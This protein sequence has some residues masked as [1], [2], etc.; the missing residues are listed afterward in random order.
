MCRGLHYC[1][2][3]LHSHRPRFCGPLSSCRACL[4]AF[5]LGHWPFVRHWL[6]SCFPASTDH[7]SLACGN[8][9]VSDLAEL[10][11]H[12]AG[13]AAALGRVTPSGHGVPSPSLVRTWL[14]VPGAVRGPRVQSHSCGPYPLLREADS[15]PGDTSA[16]V[17]RR[18]GQGGSVAAQTHVLQGWGTARRPEWPRAVAGCGQALWGSLGAVLCREYRGQWAPQA[19]GS[20]AGASRTAGV[21]G[22]LV[23]DQE[24]REEPWAA[25]SGWQLSSGQGTAA[26]DRGTSG[27]VLLWAAADARSRFHQ[28]MAS[29]RAGSR[30]Q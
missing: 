3:C 7:L 12:G 2:S 20:L 17:G 15:E 1:S 30:T 21:L 6:W 22:L 11:S 26:W 23:Q 4:R 25:L 5:V 9:P 24:G 14:H 28:A 27:L 13:R 8:S 10:V 18:R 16:P 19:G 29:K